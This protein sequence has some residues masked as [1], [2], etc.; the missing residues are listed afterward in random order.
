MIFFLIIY[1]H[2]VLGML[3]HNCH[4]CIIFAIFF[5]LVPLKLIFPTIKSTM[6]PYY[7]LRHYYK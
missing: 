6:S 3:Q 7:S 5:K 4:P 1:S 2:T